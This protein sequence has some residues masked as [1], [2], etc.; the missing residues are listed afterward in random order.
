[1]KK[2][3]FFVPLVALAIF[4]ASCTTF[5][6]EGL[7]YT[8]D[9]ANAESLGTFSRSVMV[10][11]VLGSSGGSNLANI[12][13]TAM[14]DKATAIIFNEIQKKGG[15]AARNIKISYYVGPL[16][17][18]GNWI[19]LKIW[20]PARLKISGEVIRTSS[21]TARIDTENAISNA[22]N[23]FTETTN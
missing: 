2:S 9:T 13:A 20:A 15:N 1:M 10:H 12:S 14:S 7:T 23:Q 11:E 16:A 17:Y 19:T 4:F 3:F 6:M 5:Q 18:F 8:L 21:Q 22:V